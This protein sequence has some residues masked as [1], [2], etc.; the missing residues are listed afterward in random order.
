LFLRPSRK[1]Q[2]NR[3]TPSTSWVHRGRRGV[4]H[5]A[6]LRQEQFSAKRQRHADGVVEHGHGAE[7]DEDSRGPDPARMQQQPDRD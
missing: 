5:P 4:E 3:A 2:K 1:L 7:E 6:Q